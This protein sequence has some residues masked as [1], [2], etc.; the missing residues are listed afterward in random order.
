[1]YFWSRLYYRIFYKDCK[2]TNGNPYSMYGMF[3]NGERLHG[4]LLG[5]NP[6]HITNQPERNS[7]IYG[8]S[9]CSKIWNQTWT[10]EEIFQ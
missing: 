9:G 5:H 8:C 6:A 1:M 4:I 3:T 2:F 10:D 7:G